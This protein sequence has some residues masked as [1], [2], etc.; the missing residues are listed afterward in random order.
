MDD[1][2]LVAYRVVTTNGAWGSLTT[3]GYASHRTYYLYC[4]H[5]R[6]GHSHHWRSLHRGTESREERF[7]YKVGIVLTQNL[8]AQLHHLHTRDAEST[9]L[10]TIDDLTN[11]LSLYAAGFQ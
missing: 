8:I 7:V 5:A 6:D 11:Q 9:T 3:I 1:V 10:K 4:L 2:L